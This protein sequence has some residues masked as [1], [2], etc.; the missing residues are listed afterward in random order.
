MNPAWWYFGPAIL[1]QIIA[2][3]WAW[4][5]GD[6]WSEAWWWLIVWPVGLMWPLMLLGMLADIA[7]GPY[8]PRHRSRYH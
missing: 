7:D 1:T 6:P 5:R 3:I 4:R 8:V 2:P